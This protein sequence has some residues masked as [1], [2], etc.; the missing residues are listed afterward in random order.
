VTER[1][2]TLATVIGGTS[3]RTQSDPARHGVRFSD[4]PWG[5]RRDPLTWTGKPSPAQVDNG[6]PD[7][8]TPRGFTGHEMLDDLGLVHMNGRI[9]DPLIGRFLSA[10]TLIQFPGDLQSYNRYSYVQNN[11]LSHRD[12]SGHVLIGGFVA[13]FVVDVGFQIVSNLATGKEWHNISIG[14]ALVSGAASAAG[15]GTFALVGK[16]KK[17][18][19]LRIMP[20][21]S[22]RSLA[23]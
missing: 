17:A 18:T 2:A 4:D 22:E 19:T 16:V 6:G 8:R 23:S 20:N 5:E 14:S 9:Y 1:F 21:R 7:G 10:D 11:P 13:G 15:V 3:T 12:P